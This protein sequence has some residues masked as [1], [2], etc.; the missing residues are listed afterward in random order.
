MLVGSGGGHWPWGPV[1]I[2]KPVF[3]RGW[4]LLSLGGIKNKCETRALSIPSGISCELFPELAAVLC[5]ASP[6]PLRFEESSSAPWALKFFLF[7]GKLHVFSLS[8]G[9]DTQHR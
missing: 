4:G 9:F 1:L 8:W 5:F 2:E 7:P 6:W 3:L